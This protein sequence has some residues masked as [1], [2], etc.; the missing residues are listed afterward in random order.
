MR[1]LTLV[2]LSF[3]FFLPLN[4]QTFSEQ[5]QKAKSGEGSVIIYQESLLKYLLDGVEP[6][7][8]LSLAPVFKAN[9]R[10]ERKKVAIHKKEASKVEDEHSSTNH[11]LTSQKKT[12]ERN[13]ITIGEQESTDTQYKVYRRSYTINGYRVQIYSGDNSREARR[14]ASSLGQIV[15][16]NF[17]DVPV[18]THF[19]S[20]HWICH[21]GNFRTYQAANTFLHKLK[22]IGKFGEAT[23]IKTKIQ[24]GINDD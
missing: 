23:I 21:A 24:V 16:Y 7:K 19:Y 6:K 15:K 18:Y 13:T 8:E 9:P 22:E 3:T 11:E 1:F 20:P 4:A 2:F 17:P 14:K 10:T 12:E 5:L